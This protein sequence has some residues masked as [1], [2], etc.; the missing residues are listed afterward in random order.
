MKK[1]LLVIGID[2]A[3]WDLIKVWTDKGYLPTFKKL[4]DNGTWG[5]LESTIPPWT[6]PAWE[7]MTTGKSPDKLGFATFTIRENYKFIPY[8]FKYKE[9]KRIW[10]FLSDKGYKVVVANL[11]NIY[12][13]KEI[14]GCLI[15]GWLCLDKNNIMYPKDLIDEINNHCGGYKLDIFDVDLKSG[16]LIDKSINDKE[17]IKNCEDLLE[18]HFSVFKYLL[19]KYEWDFG[20]LVFVSPDR[21]MHRCWDEEIL[22]N[23]YKKIDEKIKELLKLIDDNTIIFLVSDHGFGQIKY[24]LRINEFFIREGYLHLKNI[25]KSKKNTIIVYIYNLLKKLGLIPIIKSFLKIL[26]QNITK[27]LIKNI[28]PINYEKMDIDWKNTKAFA[29]SVCGDIY[30][31]VKGRDPQGTVDVS[32]YDNLRNEIIKKIKNIG[33]EKKLNIQIFKKEEV[34]P[35]ATL[36]DNFPDLIIVPTDDGIQLVNPN[37]EGGEIIDEL[38]ESRGNHRLNGIFLAY[39]PGIRKDNKIENAKIYDITPTIL[40]IFG[41]PIPNDVDGKVL[42]EIFEEDSAFA[43]RKPKYVDP[44]YYNKELYDKKLKKAIKKLKLKGKI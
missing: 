8:L 18:N 27:N 41:L 4:I 13:V 3:T 39:G 40:H 23:H 29:Y 19:Q 25:S 28:S 24:I 12:S 10:D 20:F 17:Y 15:C 37:I 7:S 9:Q 34:F 35:T 1:K 38:N 5:I 43:K 21:I 26:P 2:G 31:N 22:L 36:K 44:N 16:I 6:I 14:N 33:Y 32:E 11:P 42:M 30:L